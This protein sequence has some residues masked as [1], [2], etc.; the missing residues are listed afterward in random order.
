[1]S[2][3]LTPF[4]AHIPS[5][6]DACFERALQAFLD[7]P[8]VPGWDILIGS[9]LPARRA[10]AAREAT[11]RARAH[12]TDP[13]LLFHCLLRTGPTADLLSL[14]ESG[15]VEPS[16]IAAAAHDAP[17]AL[18][19]LWWAL[20]AQAALARGEPSRA[21]L[22]LHRALRIDPDHPGVA[23]VMARMARRMRPTRRECA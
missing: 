20:A 4:D 7:R 17:V 23:V 13:T 15:A 21:E 2:L 12:G 19:A 3:R 14:M 10:Q 9:V 22:L 16:T 8:S 18:K 5:H 11:V 1:M 6:A